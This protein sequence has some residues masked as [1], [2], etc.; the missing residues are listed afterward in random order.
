MVRLPAQE[1]IAETVIDNKVIADHRPR[2]VRG[3]PASRSMR[4]PRGRASIHRLFMF[5]SDISAT[6]SLTVAHERRLS[7]N[8]ATAIGPRALLSD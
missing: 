3:S 7:R 1:R 8:F 4:P 5:C 6:N 2:D